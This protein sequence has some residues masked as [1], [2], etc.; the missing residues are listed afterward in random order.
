MSHDDR[1]EVPD[2][3][4]LG[5]V[6][7]C[8]AVRAAGLSPRGPQHAPEPID[9]TIIQQD[10]AP[11][12]SVNIGNDVTLW[13]DNGRAAQEVLDPDLSTATAPMT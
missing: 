11:G 4:G 9:G 8:G 2:V 1:V 6:E 3:T 13:S 12:V 5:A 10:P 7:A